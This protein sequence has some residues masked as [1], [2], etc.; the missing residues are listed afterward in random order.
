ML[1]VKVTIDLYCLLFLVILALAEGHIGKQ[2][3]VAAFPVQ[4]LTDEVIHWVLYQF[5]LTFQVSIY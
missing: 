2:T 1:Q 5:S 3:C 4:F